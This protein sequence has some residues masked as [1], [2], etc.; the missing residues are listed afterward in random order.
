MRPSPSSRNTH[1]R[2]KRRWRHLLRLSH[3]HRRRPPQVAQSRDRRVIIVVVVFG[4]LREVST[5]AVHPKT[6]SKLPILTSSHPHRWNTFRSPRVL[7]IMAAV[8]VVVSSHLPPRHR[9]RVDDI[10]R[11]EDRYSYTQEQ[12]FGNFTTRRTTQ[13]ARGGMTHI[14]CRDYCYAGRWIVD[15]VLRIA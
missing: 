11:I 14:I 6:P 1:I 15:C 9:C 8:L 4:I 5:A 13:A 10:R 3:R 12:C 7:L 2:L